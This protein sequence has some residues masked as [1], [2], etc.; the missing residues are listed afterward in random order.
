MQ[1]AWNRVADVICGRVCIL[2]GIVLWQTNFTDGL[3][4]RGSPYMTVWTHSY[5]LLEYFNTSSFCIIACAFGTRPYLPGRAA[6]DND[7]L[8]LSHMHLQSALKPS[9]VF[10]SLHRSYVDDFLFC[11]GTSDLPCCLFAE[12]LR[13]V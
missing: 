10:V 6:N 12:W 11:L 9:H 4:R 13:S 1:Y 8:L 7:V 3:V 5:R 2:Q